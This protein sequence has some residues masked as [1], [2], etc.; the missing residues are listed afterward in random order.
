MK[1]IGIQ[2]VETIRKYIAEG[3]KFKRT[4]HMSFVPGWFFNP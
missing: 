1:C 4:I 2:Y 3:L